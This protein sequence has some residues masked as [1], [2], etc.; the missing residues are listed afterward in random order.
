MFLATTGILF[1][2]NGSLIPV[3][4]SRF[5]VLRLQILVEKSP[6]KCMQGPCIFV[7]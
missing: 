5:I 2:G 3:Y 4:F 6:K 7:F 1:F